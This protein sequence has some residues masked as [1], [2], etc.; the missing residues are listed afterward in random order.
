MTRAEVLLVNPNLM[1]PPI[2]PLGLEYVGEALERA[3]YGVAWC[4][5]AF[6]EDWRGALR[7]AVEGVTACAVGVSIRNLDDAYFASQDF[8]LE[9]SAEIVREIKALTETP[10]VLGGVGFSIAPREVLGYTGADYGIAG[11][12]ETAFPALLE[13]L[14]TGHSVGGVPGAVYRAE[15]GSIVVNGVACC[16]VEDWHPPTRRFADHRRYFAEG[17]QAGLETKRGC[18]QRCVYCVEPQAKGGAVRLRNP[19]SVAGEMAV[20]LDQGVDVFHLCDSEF[21]LPPDHAHA[22]CAAIVRRGI[23]SRVRWYAYNYP[24]PLDADLARAMARAGCVGINFGVDHSHPGILRR[25]GRGYGPEAIRNAAAAVRET[26]MALMFDLLL[27]SP[28]ETRRTLSEAIAFMREVGPDRVGLSCGVR[29]YPYTALAAMVLGQGALSANPHLH[30]ATEDNDNL[31]RPIFYVDA[32]IDGDI[33]RVVSEEV[34]GDARF[35]HADPSQLDGN[36]NYNDNSVLAEAIRSGARGA[37][38]DILRRQ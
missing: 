14:R 4:D 3:G 27:G 19:E 1:R 2:A 7:E 33:H 17:G 32:G 30:G 9:K 23:A 24:E 37:Y 26:D 20:L 8:I 10:V 12:G 35:L 18:G 16:A 21:N 11:D 15:N 5:L 28:G 22:V 25:L 31:L 38:W 13:A 34:A 29:V 36:Y 6:A